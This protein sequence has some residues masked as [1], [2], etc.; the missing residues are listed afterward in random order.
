LSSPAQWSAQQQGPRG[1]PGS[2]APQR[3][4]AGSAASDIRTII[5]R[6]PYRMPEAKL[7]IEIARRRK[8]RY[9]LDELVAGIT[10]DNRHEAI[11][12]GPPVDNEVW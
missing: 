6:H 10:P 1:S 2:S 4:K 7:V 11:D 5:C 3:F 12:W 9:A 8:R